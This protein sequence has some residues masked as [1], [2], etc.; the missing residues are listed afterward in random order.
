MKKSLFSSCLILIV[1]ALSANGR[2][3]TDRA[4]E[5][6]ARLDRSGVRLQ[7]INSSIAK[8][9]ISAAL[10]FEDLQISISTAPAS[11]DQDH[12]VLVPLGDTAWLAVWTDKRNGSSK[13]FGQVLDDTGYPVG[14]NFKL[15]G[16]DFGADYVDP[17][18]GRDSLN[19]VALFYRDRTNGL[20]FGRRYLED[21]TI[22]HP[23]FLVNDTS[24][25]SYA[26]P[27]SAAVYPSGRFV[28]VWENYS[29]VGSTIQARLYASAG[30]AVTAPVTVNTDGGA[31]SHWVPS[32]AVRPSGG[33]LVVWEDYRNSQ[34]DIY[35]ALFDGNGAPVGADFGFVPAP[36]DTADQYAPRVV[37]SNMHQY[38]VGWIDQREGQ[39]AYVQRYDRLTGLVGS[40]R[41]VTGPDAEVT[42]WD[43]SLTVDPSGNLLTE[44]AAYSAV[45]QIKAVRLDASLNPVGSPTI[46]NQIAEAQRW[47]P[48]GSYLS[49]S[50]LLLAWTDLAGNEP[51]IRAARYSSN[52]VSLT[53]EMMLND[54]SLGAVSTHPA[55]AGSDWYHVFVWQEQSADDGDIYIRS[56]NPAG[57]H[58]T[59]PTRVNQDESGNLQGEPA[60]SINGST[61]LVVWVDGRAITGLSGQRIFGRRY[62]ESG[63]LPAEEFKI[64]DDLQIA[65]KSE[66]SAALNP[67]GSGLVVWVDRRGSSPQIYG[68]WISLAG[69][70]IGTNFAISNSVADLENGYVSVGIDDAGRYFVVWLDFG[71]AE[72]TVRGEFYHADRTHA[73]SFSWTSDLPGISVAELATATTPDGNEVV[74]WT[75]SDPARTEIY[76]AVLDSTGGMVQGS[77]EISGGAALV[78]SNLTI[79][80]DENGYAV[81]GWLDGRSGKRAG[82]YQIFDPSFSPI[83]GNVAFSSASPELMRAPAV[84]AHRGRAWY[85]WADPRA[86]GMNV[87]AGSYVY[88]PTGVDDDDT[89]VLPVSYYLAQNYPNPFNPSTTIKF[90][91]PQ[92]TTARLAIFNLLGQEVIVLANGRFMAGTHT[93]VWDGQ[94]TGGNRVTSGVYF[95]RL[96]TDSFSEQRKMVLLK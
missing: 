1:L 73:G 46:I 75:K 17:I 94:D 13:I 80:V 44:W 38:V 61:G 48:T 15:A 64:S 86:D 7:E 49:T 19:R 50:N 82:Y 43:I 24:A 72:P 16:S 45:N 83:G 9:G 79:S 84:L 2:E 36:A 35:G 41:R 89:D 57:Q 65:P 18:L 27:I 47:S 25:V 63:L 69:T 59:Y 52:L 87:Y 54:D 92:A 32:V 76:F 39:E 91:L 28:V 5:H 66:P 62:N 3:G 42:N 33:F 88:L 67:D 10:N 56:V 11:F 53:S 40:N 51:D 8:S 23:T 30:T 26:G 78:A 14:D 74:L 6:A 96:T 37:Y 60:I 71:Q 29:V 77:T 22:D 68:Q 58:T 85:S 55:L 70:L 21:L 31:V 93:L 20:V 4:R 95:Y 12:S 34:A 81:A 90:N